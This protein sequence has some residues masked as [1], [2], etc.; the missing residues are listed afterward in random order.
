[1]VLGKAEEVISSLVGNRAVRMVGGTPKLR[2]SLV[3]VAP[4]QCIQTL[5]L[6]SVKV[7]QNPD[8]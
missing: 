4:E 1:M 6:T 8:L 3:F 7:E 5:V 2:I